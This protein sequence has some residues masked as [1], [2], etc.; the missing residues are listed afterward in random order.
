[1]HSLC[2]KFHIPQISASATD[3]EFYF[4]LERYKYLLRMSPSD[5][6]M[7]DAMRDLIEHFK[8]ERMGILTSATVYDMNALMEFKERATEKQ[9]EIL[10]IEHF[11]V[12]LGSPKINATK[13]LWSLREKGARVILL[14][15]SATFVPQ[16]LQQAEQL[17]MITEW[18]WILT[19]HASSKGEE[20][21]SYREG[22]IGV[23][24][25]VM[26]RGQLF[27]SVTEEWKKSGET[28]PII[29]S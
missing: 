10:G 15:C 13:E 22:L 14:S 2:S 1:M 11:P 16:V 21:I 26:G 24:M 28:A 8:W 29:V 25:P 17:D 6:R 18:V 19:D 9:W 7:N 23:R 27:D 3:P 20:D 12:T 5:L 4:N